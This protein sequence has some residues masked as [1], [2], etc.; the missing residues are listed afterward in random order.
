MS[1]LKKLS[2]VTAVNDMLRKGY[3]NICTIDTIARMLGA[4][5]KGDAYN[6]LRTLHCVEFSTMPPE[7]RDAV[8]ELIR[9]C[10]DVAPTYQ[11][12]FPIP[13]PVTIDRVIDAM[14]PK[15]GGLLRRLTG[16]T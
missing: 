5:P 13:A 8:P 1:D 7:L 9:Q 4:D 14:P 11:F 15:E 3:A 10:L 16:R 12:E 6:I 2:A